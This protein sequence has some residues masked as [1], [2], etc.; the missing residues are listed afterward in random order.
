MLRV[1]LQ[2]GRAAEEAFNVFYYLTYEVA[3]PVRVDELRVDP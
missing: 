2:R 3:P 1:P